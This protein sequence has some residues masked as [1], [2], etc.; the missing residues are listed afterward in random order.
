MGNIPDLCVNFDTLSS[1][2]CTVL[3]FIQDGKFYFTCSR[4]QALEYFCR[5]GKQAK[6]LSP[7]SLIKDLAVFYKTSLKAYE[8]SL[9]NNKE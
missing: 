8:H 1:F 9:I 7:A 3:A 5:F 4:E 2:F 6:A